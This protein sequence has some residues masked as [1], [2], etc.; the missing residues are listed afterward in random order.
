MDLWS[1]LAIGFGAALTA[2]NLLA[3]F[4]GTLIGTLVGVLPGLGPIATMAMLLPLTSALSPLTGLIMLA[5]IYYGAQYG[6]ST[7]AILVNLPG[8]SSSIVTCLDGHPM[9]RQ[10]RAGP[11]LAVA[12]LGSLFAG[13]VVTLI[14]GA[15]APALAEV[16][17]RFGPAD[18]FSLM[19]LG[20]IFATVLAAGS[21]LKA[22]AMVGF[23]LVLGLVGTDIESGAHRLTFG[24]PQFIEG[25]PFICLAVGLFGIAEI[26]LNLE[27]QEKGGDLISRPTGLWPTAAD[28]AASVGPVLRGTAIGAVLGLLPGGGAM[29]ASFASYVAEKRLARDPSR[30][31]HGAIEGVAGPESA[32]NAGAQASFI[33]LLTLGIPANAVM[34]VMVGAMVAKGI[35]PGPRIIEMQPVLFWG[36]I[37]SMLIGNVMLVIINLPLIGLWVRLLAVPYRLLFPTILILCAIGVYS[38]D[39]S[40]FQVVLTMVIG[41]V[42]YGLRKLGFEPAPILLGFVLGPLLEEN[43][44]RALVLSRGDLSVFVTEPLSAAFLVCACFAA[45]A[46]LL[47]A[48]R[49][50]REKLSET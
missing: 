10:G 14:T 7:T 11:A 38:V 8:E 39:S 29:L 27:Q 22:L 24:S 42:G 30:F 44:R 31:G 37:A 33:P 18:T 25:V 43:M 50:T 26:A 15:A 5:G 12:A 34:A 3:C 48:M 1:G 21:F 47:P 13:I 45:A 6:G 40:P 16:A 4:A 28:A 46:I 17:L 49:R 23:G 19:V 2:E 41:M 35:T 32:N 9:A 20:L 36:L